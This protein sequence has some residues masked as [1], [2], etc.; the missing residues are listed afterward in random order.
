MCVK[1]FMQK[2]YRAG[3]SLKKKTVS[4]ISEKQF[5]QLKKQYKS[6]SNH[7]PPSTFLGKADTQILL[8]ISQETNVHNVNNIT[9]TKAYLDFF[10]ENKEIHWSF[11]AHMVSRNGGWNMTDLKGSLLHH[12]IP[13]DKEEIF[14]EFLERANFTIFQDA[15]P[16][17]L[18]Y[19]YSKKTG[20]NLFDLL[21]YF[22]VSS[23]MDPIWNYFLETSN[24]SLLTVGLI[25]NE[26]QLLQ[27]RIINNSKY[28]TEVLDSI[29][30]K[31]QEHLGFTDVLIPFKK[32][33]KTELAGVT[34]YGFENV[35]NRIV[36]GKMLYGI[37]FHKI[38]NKA[39]S[40]ATN[41]SHTGSRADF[42]PDVFTSKNISQVN[43]NKLIYS[44]TLDQAWPNYSHPL[45]NDK[46]WFNSNSID[47]IDILKTFYIPKAYKKSKNYRKDIEKLASLNDI[48]SY[49]P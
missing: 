36:I 34:V 37:L 19:E 3:V 6:I 40:F 16:Q 26:Q 18:L 46:D 48:K 10:K 28:E 25:I 5:L 14:F 45:S 41:I 44:P 31:T 7:R 39:I 24:S 43:Q 1:S 49:F 8:S 29:L 2:L 42:W 22:S 35:T 21:P 32:K 38:Y 12:L 27:S 13:S 20:R 15:Y 47:A 4:T 23:F 9:R 11:L 17:L 30:F 33:H